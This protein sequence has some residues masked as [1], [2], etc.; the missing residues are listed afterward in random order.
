MPAG[1]MAACVNL[2][3]CLPVGFK[4]EF[5]GCGNRAASPGG[6]DRSIFHFTQQL[7]GSSA[8]CP[9]ARLCRGASQVR[10]VSLLVGSSRR[11]GRRSFAR[12]TMCARLLAMVAARAV[13]GLRCVRS[14]GVSR[15]FALTSSVPS[16][17]TDLHP[18]PATSRWSSVVSHF[19]DGARPV[20]LVGARRSYRMRLPLPSAG[21]E[22]NVLSFGRP[23]RRS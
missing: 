18:S 5:G 23:G 14:F 13:S 19:F 1:H 16:H 12:F 17:R 11:A 7:V 6:R 21:T 2:P 20:A 9:S 10:A 8:R 15:S 3:V 4:H 22:W